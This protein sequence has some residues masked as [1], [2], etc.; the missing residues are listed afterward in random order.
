VPY[1]FKYEYELVKA[2]PLEH[3]AKVNGAVTTTSNVSKDDVEA[4]Y[5]FCVSLRSNF[6]HLQTLFEDGADLRR[7]LLQSVAPTFFKDMN[8]MLIEHLILQIC[9]ITDP[10]ESLGRKN[11][12]LKFLINNSDFS[13]APVESDR[14]KR[15]GDSMHAFR[16][17]IVPARNRLIGH[18]DRHS[19]LDGKALGGADKNS[20]DQFWLDLQEFVHIL[21]KH[22]IDPHGLIYLN[23]IGHLSDA[24]DLVEAIKASTYFHTLLDNEKLTKICTDTA[25]VSKYFTA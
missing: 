24:D 3:A 6:H 20:W 17:K 7:E 13:N 9:K 5:G 1:I 2:A 10:E 18:L 15:L 25:F 8:L 11:L 23:D 12:T 14:L 16:M 4:F 19:V 22:Y 21:H